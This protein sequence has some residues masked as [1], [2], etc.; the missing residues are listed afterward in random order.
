[1]TP[2]AA[3]AAIEP[4]ERS[5]LADEDALVVRHYAQA[6]VDAAAA[7]NQAETAL[8]D[9][10]HI[11]QEVLRVHPQFKQILGSS[12]V[13]GSEKDRILVN[14]FGDRVC[15][16]VLRFLRVLNRHGR[17]GLLASLPREARQIWDRRHKRVEVFIRTA[18]P[19]DEDQKEALRQRV[20]AM[21]SA[22]PI[23]RITTDPSLI[24][25]L[26]VQVGDQVTDASVRNGLEKIRQRLLEGKTHEI[27]SRRDQFSNPA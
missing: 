26:I 8:E 20:A 5:L 14:V 19:L 21:I 12:Q 3:E 18:I 24:G 13:S 25:G 2:V 27:Q 6:L 11:D 7:E 22:T 17:L 9:L 16:V 15:S 4:D 23:M 1:M 10:E